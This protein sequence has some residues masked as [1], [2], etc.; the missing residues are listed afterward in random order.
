MLH[1]T[2]LSNR[3]ISEDMFGKGTYAADL[4]EVFGSSPQ[5]D[6][7]LLPDP[8]TM[9]RLPWEPNTVRFI[10]DMV[11]ASS[12][13]RFLKD[14]RYVAERVE[15][16]LEA[17]GLKICKVGTQVECCIFD[18]V[19]TDRTAPGRGSGTVLDSREAK[20][21]PSPLSSVGKGAWVCQP[22]DSLYA[23]RTQICETMEDSFGM[24]VDAH[25]HGR[26]QTAQQM[27]ELNEKTLK[28]SADAVST[29]KFVVRNLA[30]AVNASSTFMPYP[31]EGE[32]GNALN[33]AVSLWK[34]ADNNAFYEG[35]EDYAQLSQA[36]YYFVGGLL[37]HAAALSLF[38]AP[39]S[40]SYRRLAMD[41]P[42]VGWSSNAPNALV[43]VPMVKKNVKENKRVM[44]C[45]G[46]PSGNPHLA[47]AMVVAAGLE[48]IKSK[49]EPGEPIES[50]KKGKRVAKP[51]PSTLYEAM[52]ALESDNKFIKGVVPSEL[53][54]DYLD[55]KLAEYKSERKAVSGYELQRYY[56]V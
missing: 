36:G 2:S 52:E 54:G 22:F 29:L 1:K 48:G 24:S 47:I 7:A 31:V 35:K 51:L 8:D 32:K 27:F 40:N 5:G 10:C 25:M 37:E 30:N 11:A 34:A 18:T 42:V 14:S 21:G 23:A 45:G 12:G 56:N 43:K 39:T 53:L 49:I 9:A 6:L 20:W 17:A 55:M 3:K 46:D 19:T 50:E 26:S 4:N 44:Y 15:T 38:V 28:T 13:D 33:I 41:P 16:N